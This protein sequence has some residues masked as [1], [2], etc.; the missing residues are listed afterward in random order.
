VHCTLWLSCQW[1]QAGD[2]TADVG[3]VQGIKATKSRPNSYLYQAL[4]L[5][6]TELKYMEE[7]RQ[8]FMEGT[9][10][11]MVSCQHAN[12]GRFL[13]LLVSHCAIFSVV[14]CL[15]LLPLF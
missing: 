2:V 10:T 13:S 3:A 7:A 14:A 12:L 1:T 9:K 5:M 15:G 8:W 4:A 6:A 11:V